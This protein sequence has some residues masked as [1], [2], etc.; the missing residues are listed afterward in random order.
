MKQHI[1]FTLVVAAILGVVGIEWRVLADEPP[2]PTQLYIHSGTLR[3][4][5]L[6]A[7]TLIVDG[8]STPVKFVVPTDAKIIVKDKP[9]GGDLSDLMVGDPIQIKYTD[10]DDAHVAH[11]ISVL[12]I[13]SP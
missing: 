11:E 5:D 8:S 1:A 13:K 7:R 2:A 4:I 10:D 9:Q 3:S 6:R 12:G